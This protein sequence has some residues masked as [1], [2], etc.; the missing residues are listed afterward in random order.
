M[1]DTNLIIPPAAKLPA[2][3]DVMEELGD[4]PTPDITSE[5][6]QAVRTIEKATTAKNLKGQYVNLLRSA[7]L[8]VHAGLNVLAHRAQTERSGENEEITARLR[9][10][11][12]GL[13]LEKERLERELDQAAHD[14]KEGE[15]SQRENEDLKR[16]VRRLEGELLE[17]KERCIAEIDGGGRRAGEGSRAPSSAPSPPLLLQLSPSA[18][19]GGC[20]RPPTK[21][22]GD[23]RSLPLWGGWQEDSTRVFTFSNKWRGKIVL[24]RR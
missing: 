6:M 4:Q 13:K 19:E 22:G 10:K 17:I 12:K 21:A 2:V 15:R 20:G 3:E 18:V 16:N 24:S 11:V 1:A 8:K 5:L 9:R 14:R 7:A 23:P